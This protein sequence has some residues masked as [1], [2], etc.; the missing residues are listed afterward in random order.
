MC[1]LQVATSHSP[2]EIPTT[3]ALEQACSALYMVRATSAKFGLHVGN[4]KFNTQNDE[5]IRI[6]TWIIL[7]NIL[8][9]FLMARQPL[10]GLGRL[11][12]RGFTITHFLDSPQSVGLLWTSDQP[13]AE[14]STWQ[15]T[16]LTTDRQPCPGGIRNHNTSKVAAADPRLRPHG[17][18]DRL[19]SRL[20]KEIPPFHYL[21][22]IRY[23]DSLSVY[24]RAI[25]SC[26]S[27]N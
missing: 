20:V 15:H 2:T 18:W 25:E 26:M 8:M 27:Y 1:P 21:L 7:P 9:F 22:W 12:F 10:G 24:R 14:T 16:T 4:M 13:V 6:I 17:H 19:F 5:W 11:I 23:I 3:L